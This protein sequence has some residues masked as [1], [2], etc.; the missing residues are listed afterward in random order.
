MS[1]R[2]PSGPRLTHLGRLCTSWPQNTPTSLFWCFSVNLHISVTTK[3]HPHVFSPTPESHL[4]EKGKSAILL[5]TARH[6]QCF[7]EVSNDSTK[8]RSLFIIP[9]LGQYSIQK[10]HDA[11]FR[12]TTVDLSDGRSDE[13]HSRDSEPP[14]LDLWCIHSVDLHDKIPNRDLLILKQ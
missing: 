3:T 11:P 10:V 13:I 5:Y 9:M 4:V 12:I 6:K 14:V 8:G 1:S 7:Y 2:R